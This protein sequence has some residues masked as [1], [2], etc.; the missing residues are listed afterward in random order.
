MSES[1]PNPA[2]GTDAATATGLTSESEAFFFGS[3]IAVS[4]EA[5]D[6][7]LSRLWKPLETG[8]EAAAAVTRACLS[9]VIFYLP[10][11]AARE[12]ARDLVQAVG[13][14]FPSRM[15]L[16]TLGETSSA[17]LRLKAAINAVCHR[18][19]DGGQPICCEQISLEAA[20][21]ALDLFPGA[22]VP[23]LVPDVPVNLVLLDDC[24]MEIFEGLNDVVDR[25]IFDSRWLDTVALTRVERALSRPRCPATDDLAWRDI[26]GWRCALSE[27]FDDAAARSILPSVR[28]VEIRHLRGSTVRCELLLAWL[29]SRL[30][31]PL[32]AVLLPVEGDER[33]AGRLVSV[34]LAASDDA[35][36][37]FVA[38]RRVDA[39]NLLRVEYHTRNAC[40]IPRTI[41]TRFE[42]DDELLGGALERTTHQGVLRGVIDWVCAGMRRKQQLTAKP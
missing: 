25:L 36:S 29:E 4:P 41:F 8:P 26:V 23:L 13:R 27:I 37:N 10:T 9:N 16:L 5:I 31:T 34:R 33:E 6:R 30:K 7:E 22:V 24:G 2:P 1:M 18:G 42:T 39:S 21:S 19:E 11:R 38:V 40:V 32:A 35:G 20:P 28:N 17:E 14:R 15:F 12:L 3:P